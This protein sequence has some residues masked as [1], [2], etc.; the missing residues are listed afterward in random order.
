MIDLS[1]DF[2]LNDAGVYHEFYGAEHPSPEWLAKAVYGLL[3]ARR[4]AIG[5]A[6]L[7]ASPGCY[8]TSIL[9]PIIPLLEAG[10]IDPGQIIATRSA[11]SAVWAATPPYPSCTSSATRAC[12]RTAYRNTGTSRRRTGTRLGQ[13]LAGDGAHPA[14]RPGKSRHPHHALPRARALAKRTIS[15]NGQ[16]PSPTVWQ[17]LCRRA[18][19]PHH[20]QRTVARHEKRHRT[21]RSKW[22][23]RRSANQAASIFS[24]EDNLRKASGQAVQSFN[25]RFGF[26]ETAGLPI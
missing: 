12:G 3:E 25:I 13:R 16:P 19:R 22:L 26:D 4:D 14:P 7:I 15:I 23:G 5:D 11:A 8:P 2:R 6:T 10:L 9:L 1:A 24:A 17:A 20:R 18:I 21:N